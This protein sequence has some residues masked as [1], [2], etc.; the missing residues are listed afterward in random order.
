MLRPFV[1]RSIAPIPGLRSDLERHRHEIWRDWKVARKRQS[2]YMEREA[3]KAVD[4]GLLRAIREQSF[5][6]VTAW[7]EMR[8][9]VLRPVHGHGPYPVLVGVE[10]S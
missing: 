4:A 5:D 7:A 9:A 1:P 3:K 2:A 6:E 8:I 10:Q